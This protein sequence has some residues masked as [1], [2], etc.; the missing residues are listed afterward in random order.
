M[1]RPVPQMNRWRAKYINT[2]RHR[3]VLEV[4]GIV[5]ALTLV[6]FLLPSGFS[7]VLCKY[8]SLACCLSKLARSA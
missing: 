7:Y 8:P 1:L 2:H 6:A 4:A 3:R 5:T